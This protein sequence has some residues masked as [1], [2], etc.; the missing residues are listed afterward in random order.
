MFALKDLGEV[1]YFLGIQVKRT[2]NGI[3]LSQKKYVTDLLC[4]TKMQ[5]AN[6]VSAPMTTGQKLTSYG[7]DPI[8]DVQLY[9]SVV[10]A[11]QYATIN[12]LEICFSVNK[13]C[14]FMQSPL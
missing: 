1:D 5:Y 8:E 12:W 7:S 9:R 11:L 13:V 14:Q 4:K 10:G 2:E 6:C 3:D